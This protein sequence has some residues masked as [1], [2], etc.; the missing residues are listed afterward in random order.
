MGNVIIRFTLVSMLTGMFLS[1]WTSTGHGNSSPEIVGVEEDWEM[2]LGE[3]DPN[4]S[5]PQILT[6]MSPTQTLQD[7]HFGIDFNLI[8][9]PDFSSGGFQTRAFDGETLIESRFSESGDKLSHAGESIRWTQRMFLLNNQ[10]S[11]EVANGT[12]Q[13]WGTFGET[14]TRVI[15]NTSRVSNLNNYSPNRSLEWSGIGFGANRVAYLRLK[16][17]RLFTVD[18][19]VNTVSLDADIE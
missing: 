5:A 8:Q 1:L 14:S 15:F 18:G 13:S 16:T 7:Q 6:W 12:S 19:N 3:P 17:V 10:L 11:F 4:K 9:R 2:V